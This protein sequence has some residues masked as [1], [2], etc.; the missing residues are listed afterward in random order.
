MKKNTNKDFSSRISDAIKDR[1]KDYLNN[2]EFTMSYNN[3]QF[4]FFVKVVE[5]RSDI[6]KKIGIP[7]ELS[8]GKV[9]QIKLIVSGINKPL[10]I[11]IT[12]VNIAAK[13]IFISKDLKNDY[14]NNIFLFKMCFQGT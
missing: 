6:L 12:G 11:E 7:L 13:T 10:V 1:L 9:E 3:S 4:I 8:E 14:N 5:V 2:L